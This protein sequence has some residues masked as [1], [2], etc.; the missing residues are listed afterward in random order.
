MILLSFLDT[1]GQKRNESEV[2][3]LPTR[4]RMTLASICDAVIVTDPESR[5][6]FMNPTAED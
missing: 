4:F 5:I 3:E 1:T 6:T 2:D